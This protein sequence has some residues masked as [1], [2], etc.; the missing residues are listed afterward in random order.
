M[1]RSLRTSAR[2]GTLP[3]NARINRTPRWPLAPVSST[4]PWG[5]CQCAGRSSAVADTPG[6]CWSLELF[7][8]AARPPSNCTTPLR[9]LRYSSPSH[10]LT[11]ETLSKPPASLLTAA[12]LLTLLRAL[13]AVPCALWIHEQL[14][15]PAAVLFTAAAFSD[16]YDGRLARA[17]GQTSAAGGLFDHA[18]D[19][20]FVSLCL[21]A[22]SSIGLITVWLA[23][24]VVLA[25]AQ[26]ALDSA[27]LAGRP[28]RA[29]GLGRSNGI[30]YFVLAGC[31]IG[32]PLLDDLIEIVD[33]P[34]NE[35][36]FAASVALCATTLVSIS[37]RAGYW[38]R[39]R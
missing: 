3:A 32:L 31:V 5:N 13:L 28:L 22:A 17:R 8:L 19:A 1:A 14:W 37:I 36:L 16:F 30:A 2:S 15:L 21:A 7:K 26:Y 18:T 35:L 23:P 9:Q 20:L 29:S 27:V 25:F 6:G 38:F 24:L 34:T 33:L 39:Y 4:G 11:S 12:N 10:P